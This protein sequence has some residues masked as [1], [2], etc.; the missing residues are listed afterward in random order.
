MGILE[1]IKDIEEEVLLQNK[2]YNFIKSI[3]GK[4]VTSKI[5]CSFIFVKY[6]QQTAFIIMEFLKGIPFN[7]IIKSTQ[8]GLLANINMKNDQFYSIKTQLENIIKNLHEIDIAHN[9]LGGNNIVIQDMSRDPIVK[10]LDFGFATPLSVAPYFVNIRKRSTTPIDY[11]G[12]NTIKDIEEV[13]KSKSCT[14]LPLK[15]E[16]RELKE[17]NS[18]TN[19]KQKKARS[20]QL[21]L[22]NTLNLELVSFFVIIVFIVIV[23]I[24]YCCYFC[25][26][27]YYCYRYYCYCII[28]LLL[29]LLLLL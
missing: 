14:P 19:R 3:D 11:T 15:Y 7:N 26:C 6:D 20:T 27:C 1:K 17:D 8:Y 2:A 10:I 13:I 24:C 5:L 9:D 21:T 4:P 29:L 22:T 16:K 23:V 18:K 25:Y 12:Y 28:A